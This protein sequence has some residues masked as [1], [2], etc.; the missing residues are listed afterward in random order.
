MGAIPLLSDIEAPRS[1]FQ[2][3]DRVIARVSMDMR[4]DQ[5]WSLIRTIKKFAKAEVRPMVLNCC[6]TELTL[7]RAGRRESLVSLTHVEP[8]TKVPNTMN[9]SLG[10]VEFIEGDILEFKVRPMNQAQRADFMAMV[11]DWTGSNVDVRI[12][13]VPTLA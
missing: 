6:K 10:K 13:H 1:K 9:L 8:D 7:I 12:I 2:D 3:G 4:G 11:R 5:L